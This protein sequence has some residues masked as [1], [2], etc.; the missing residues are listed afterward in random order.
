MSS[1]PATPHT[2]NASNVKNELEKEKEMQEEIQQIL[3]FLEQDPL[4]AITEKDI[5]GNTLFHFS[6]CD[7]QHY[8]VTQRILELLLPTL[9]LNLKNNAGRTPLHLACVG[10]AF[11]SAELLLNKGADQNEV[12]MTYFLFL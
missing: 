5:N 9:D 7:S 1:A 2:P 3:N 8:S 10:D 12:R 11:S 6:C 4:K